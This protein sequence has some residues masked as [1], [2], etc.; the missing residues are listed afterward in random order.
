MITDYM[1]GVYRDPQKWLRNIC[2]T[3]YMYDEAVL[4]GIVNFFRV[5]PPRKISSFGGGVF[6]PKC[7]NWGAEPHFWHFALKWNYLINIIY[8]YESVAGVS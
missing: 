4:K 2:M 8:C 5:S 3:P 7:Q 6:W 1:G